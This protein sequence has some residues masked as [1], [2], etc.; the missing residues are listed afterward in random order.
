VNCQDCHRFNVE[1][2]RAPGLQRAPVPSGACDA[3]H[4]NLT[5]PSIEATYDEM[6]QSVSCP[7]IDH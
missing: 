7:G 3:C 1:E 5:S 2:H 6:R 4:T